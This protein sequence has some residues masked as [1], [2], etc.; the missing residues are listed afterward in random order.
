M[1]D[2]FR[3]SETHESYKINIP[4]DAILKYELVIEEKTRVP[5]RVH[6]HHNTKTTRVFIRRREEG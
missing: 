6:P 2:N 5:K 4:I 3:K 1:T